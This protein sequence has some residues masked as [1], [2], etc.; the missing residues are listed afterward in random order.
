MGH[1][2]FEHFR[3]YTCLEGEFYMTRYYADEMARY[4]E[5]DL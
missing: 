1:A 4:Y 2:L 3:Y 5:E